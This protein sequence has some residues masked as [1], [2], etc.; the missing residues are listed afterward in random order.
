MCVIDIH[1]ALTETKTSDPWEACKVILQKKS[2]SKVI[3]MLSPKSEC[4][5]E[6]QCAQKLAVQLFL[7]NVH[8]LRQL[9]EGDLL[10]GLASPTPSLCCTSKIG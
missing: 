3:V 7:L 5:R 6:G 9:T 1:A 10:K 8:S 2:G 4:K